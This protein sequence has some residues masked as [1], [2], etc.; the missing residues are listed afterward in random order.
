MN[1]IN[2]LNLK[3]KRKDKVLKDI[4]DFI[5]KGVTLQESKKSCE[6]RE[7]RFF[8]SLLNTLELLNKRTSNMMCE[9]IDLVLYEEPFY[10]VVEGLTCKIY[11]E[12]G[13][14][15]IFW[16][17]REKEINNGKSLIITGQDGVDYPIT[18][19]LQLYKTLKKL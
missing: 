17:V 18:T 12:V 3:R 7:V 4:K 11:G 14:G 13:A 19:P 15:I 1:S 5:G 10:N 8:T 9:G 16:W 6:K 2:Y